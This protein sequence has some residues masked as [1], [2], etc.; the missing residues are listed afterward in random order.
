MKAVVETDLASISRL[1][2]INSRLQA[3]NADI[4]RLMTLVAAHEKISDLRGRIDDFGE[5][6]DKIVLDLRE[7]NDSEPAAAKK[8]SIDEFIRNLELYKRGDL[9]GR[10]D[11]GNRL[12]ERGRPS[13]LPSTSIIDRMSAQLS[14]IITVSTEKGQ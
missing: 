4:Y 6:I 7:Y 11:A 1:A 3:T 9:L 10:L 12:S 14:T 8:V 13:S 2:Q 5:R